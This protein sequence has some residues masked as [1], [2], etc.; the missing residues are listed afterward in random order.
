VSKKPLPLIFFPIEVSPK[1]R[2]Q[3]CSQR[4]LNSPSEWD[5]DTGAVSP[6]CWRAAQWTE[7]SES[8]SPAS[9]AG[10]VAR[11]Q[12]T[13]PHRGEY[14]EPAEWHMLEM[15]TGYVFPMVWEQCEY[16]LTHC[17]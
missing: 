1:E 8:L 11:G 10:M 16:F 13:F 7:A 15:G 5:K 3:R 9:A 4:S 17:W 6:A 2:A 12:R 14:I